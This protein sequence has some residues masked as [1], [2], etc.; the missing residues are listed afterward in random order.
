MSEPDEIL[1]DPET[2][3]RQVERPG[4][5]KYAALSLLRLFAVINAIGYLYAVLPESLFESATA[6][7][8]HLLG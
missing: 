1:R 3:F 5:I 4:T 6:K 7:L 2:Y 8:A